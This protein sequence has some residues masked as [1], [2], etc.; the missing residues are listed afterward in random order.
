LFTGV[1]VAPLA[2][3]L[4]QSV[5]VGTCNDPTGAGVPRAAV[6]ARN[7]ATNLTFRAL[8]DDQ[9]D[10]VF[11]TL[12]I[13]KYELTVTAT[14]FA[15]A[16]RSGI[17]L[18][19]GQR[20]RVDFALQLEAAG[21]QLE[22][23]GE[24]PLVDT[25]SSGLGAVIESRRIDE[26]PLNRRNALALAVVAP[27]VRN[28]QGGTDIGFGASSDYQVANIGINGSPS[29]FVS[30]LLD[31]GINTDTERGEVAV[32]PLVESV[33][34]FKVWTNVLPPEYGLTLGGLVNTVTRSGSNELHGSL[35][36]FLRN[37]KLDARNS[38]AAVRSPYRYNQFGA[39]IGG[40]VYLPKIYNGKNRTFFFFNYEGSRYRVTSNPITSTPI[41]AFRNGDYSNLRDASGKLILIY[42]PATT[43]PN[44][45]GSGYIRTPFTGNLIPK[46]RFDRV[47]ANVLG[48]FPEPNRPPDNPY[49]QSQNFI[50]TQAN[51]IDK[52][53]YHGR[54]DHY[55]GS[56]NRLFGRW[57]TDKEYKDFP[58]N[59]QPWS[60][61]LFYGRLDHNN[62][63][64]AVISDVHT[65][66]PTLL[67]EFRGAV[68][69]Q[70]FS[71]LVASW[72]QGWPQ[73]L[74]LPSIVPPYTF[75]IFQASGYNQL[76]GNGSSGLRYNT[77]YQVFDTVTKVAAHHVIKIGFESRLQRESNY[78]NSNPSGTFA[79]NGLLTGNP[80]SQAG[81][82]SG[83]AQLLLGQVTSGSLVVLASPTNAGYT[84]AGFV[85]DDWKVSRRL[86]L[87]LGLRYD[88]QSPPVERRNESSNFNP[89]TPNPT[90]KS[91][92]GAYQ[93]AGVDYG[94]TQATSDY[95]DFGPRFGFA[96]NL[97]SNSKTVLRGGYAI[98]YAPTFSH[99]F[100]PSN[101]GYSVT[102]SYT[103][104]NSNTNFAAFHLQDGPP[105]V[106]QPFG[107]SLG[108]NAFLG[109]AVSW[110]ESNKRTPYDQQWNFGLQ[111]QLAQ[112]WLV[113]VS[114]AGNRGLKLLSGSYNYNQ[115]DPKY[116]ALGLQLQNQVANPL[117]GQVPGTLGNA[118]VSKQQTLLPYP[119]YTTITVL[120]PR[121][122][123][124]TYHALEVRVERRLTSG[125][126]M[127]ASYTNAKLIDDSQA[128]NLD[129]LGVQTAITSYQNGKFNRR[130]ERAIDPTDVAQRLV[131]SYVY[132]LP[133]G[134]GHAI[135]VEN[136]MLNALL[137]GWSTSGLI[138]IQ[139]GLPLIVRGASNFAADRP[140]STGQSARISD[141]T[142]TQWFNTQVF[143]NPPNFTF[144]D[145]GRTLPDVR[146]PGL[147]DFDVAL[148][149]SWRVREP[150]SIRLRV[151]AFNLANVTNLGMP[152]TTFVPGAQGTNVSSTFGTISSA[153]DART[154][155]LGLKVL[156]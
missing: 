131:V 85:G 26:L 116:L 79:F 128:N 32:A 102:S 92:M 43:V 106:Q 112:H 50:A 107:S 10:Y 46:S 115:L 47:G 37:D 34:E 64:Q 18:E 96:Y 88:F 73:K 84:C 45:N 11:P 44:P 27:G 61:P 36:E 141:P 66:S 56:S 143:V 29:G 118:T 57:S 25:D 138:T 17:E 59:A 8:T 114:Y 117:T 145:V 19:V 104:P 68:M 23:K 119:Q 142:R 60:D 39:S 49:T 124:S 70:A 65:F 9:G 147:V 129:F 12:P 109:T 101:A 82:G 42:D 93:F 90:N 1:S 4:S 38:F 35:Y 126:T 99:Y 134:R 103:A 76:G 136:R 110:E 24:T 97:F 78:Q 132:E 89:L 135:P 30:F 14:G 72:D 54:V 123:A 53:Q 7:A 148:Q 22:V 149:K 74:G 152:N 3:Q 41:E 95:T 120:Q 21:Q 48:Y 75:P 154:F 2:A 63:Q 111:Q 130:V 5:I 83:I 51:F 91:L 151:E 122:G 71:F 40:P 69:R 6:T 125:L 81:T 86:T 156:W 139:G 108:A 146:G 58:T 87:N 144:G 55:L 105:F 155:Q 153:Y 52:G 28:V 140:D 100:F 98:I 113:E 13:G 20:S 137:G 121:G 150:I 31:G 77:G 33:V 94:S 67:N 80:Q 62:F 127:L 15:T 133:V 16:T